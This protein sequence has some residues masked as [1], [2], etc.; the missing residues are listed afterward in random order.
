MAVIEVGRKSSIDRVRRRRGSR[1]TAFRPGSL[2]PAANCRRKVIPNL[3]SYVGTTRSSASSMSTG[4]RHDLA[5][6]DSQHPHVDHW[7]AGNGGT[8][9]KPSRRCLPA[10]REVEDDAPKVC[11]AFVSQQSSVTSAQVIN[12]RS[13]PHDSGSRARRRSNRVGEARRRAGRQACD[14]SSAL[15]RTSATPGQQPGWCSR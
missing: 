1:L 2:P 7:S 10:R 14:A 15:V 12:G 9:L 6:W 11:N 3:R 4:W 13:M 8:E 5:G